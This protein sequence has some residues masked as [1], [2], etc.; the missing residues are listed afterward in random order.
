MRRRC[1]G[2]FRP[3]SSKRLAATARR[4]RRKGHQHA[5]ELPGHLLHLTQ[6]AWHPLMDVVALR[7]FFGRNRLQLQSL[8]PPPRTTTMTTPPMTSWPPLLPLNIHFFGR[9]TYKVPEAVTA[10]YANGRLGVVPRLE[11]QSGFPASLS[12]VRRSPVLTVEWIWMFILDP[13]AA[14]SSCVRRWPSRL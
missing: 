3:D 2:S 5:V 7:Y 4:A 11:M 12:V 6:V 9:I 10:T 1:Q 13:E 8:T 14:L